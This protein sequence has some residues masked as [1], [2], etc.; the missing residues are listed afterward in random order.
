MVWQ[1]CLMSSRLS[2]SPEFESGNQKIRKK[3]SEQQSL[4]WKMARLAKESERN[5]DPAVDDAIRAGITLHPQ[6][7]RGARRPISVVF[8]GAI[9]E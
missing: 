4:V 6:I 9:Q 7:P 2:Q 5:L 3:A 8:A 1:F